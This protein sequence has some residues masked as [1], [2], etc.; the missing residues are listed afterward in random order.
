MIRV[1]HG[2]H[3]VAELDNI[4]TRVKHWRP[5]LWL[6]DLLLAPGYDH[7]FLAFA[8]FSFLTV[9]HGAASADSRSWRRISAFVVLSP[10]T[11]IAVLIASARAPPAWAAWAVASSVSSATASTNHASP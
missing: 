4:V 9:G 3:A 6:N 7:H 8:I 5:R 2:A 1:D 10:I 11:F